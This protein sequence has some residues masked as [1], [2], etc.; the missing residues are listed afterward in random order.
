M[1]QFLENKLSRR[2]FAGLALSAFAATA[3]NITPALATNFRKGTFKGK[4]GHVTKGSV[5]VKVKDGKAFVLLGDD[6]FFDG[7][8]DP[9]LA[10]G[11]DGKHDASTY[12][13]KIL[14]KKQWKGASKHKVAANIDVSKYN[15]VYVWCEKFNVPLGV[16][17][18][19]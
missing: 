10:F 18:I 16:A 7:G 13:H 4:S 9:K 14:P 12:L 5:K 3:M 17:K 6:F 19:K 2:Q 11:K 15:E 8:P 1:S